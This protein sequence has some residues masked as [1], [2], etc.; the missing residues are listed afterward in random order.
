VEDVLV[1]RG[2]LEEGTLLSIL[3]QRYQTQFVSLTQLAR[4]TIHPNV[5]SLLSPAEARAFGV[6][7]VRMN[8]RRGVLYCVT[9]RAADRFTLEKILAEVTGCRRVCV[10][11]SRPEVVRAGIEAHYDGLDH[12]FIKMLKKARW[13]QPLVED[14][15]MYEEAVAELYEPVLEPA[16]NS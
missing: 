16:T 15:P 2:V 6:L 1:D 11:I 10:F 9:S 12:R 4:L 5:L 13:T 14:R 3:A 7:P 8:H